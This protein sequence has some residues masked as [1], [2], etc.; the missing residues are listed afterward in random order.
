M[1][2][3]V[4][5][6]ILFTL[7]KKKSLILKP[8]PPYNFDTTVFKPAHYPDHLKVYEPG[9]Y[10]FAMRL[11]NRIYGIKMEG[12]GT[13]DKPKVRVSIFFQSILSKEGIDNAAFDL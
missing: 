6:A 4:L 9:R 13:V 5:H 1:C 11:N 8:R 10:W 3:Y 2:K 12:Q 7:A